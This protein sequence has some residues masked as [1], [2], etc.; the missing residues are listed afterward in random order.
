[1][2]GGA[3]I[4]RVIQ[5]PARGQV[6]NVS[7]AVVPERA[8][9]ADHEQMEFDKLLEYA[10]LQLEV[11]ALRVERERIKA[12]RK[13]PRSRQRE[14]VQAKPR[15]VPSIVEWRTWR[16]FVRD[17]QAIEADWRRNNSG[18]PTKE[19]IATSK[20]CIGKTI[21]RTMV[22]TYGLRAEQWPPSTWP[23]RPPSA[24]EGTA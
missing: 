24:A 15:H 10:R 20:G 1:M 4:W 8:G 12:S 18:E 21:T 9:V 6:F 16:G 3:R 5:L 14:A 22:E 17:L 23:A 2:A 11:E 7:A 19:A 13:H